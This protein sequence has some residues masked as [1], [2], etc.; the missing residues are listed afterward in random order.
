MSHD[1]GSTCLKQG[2]AKLL[3]DEPNCFLDEEDRNGSAPRLRFDEADGGL[4]QIDR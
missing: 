4:K 3:L 2:T 1:S